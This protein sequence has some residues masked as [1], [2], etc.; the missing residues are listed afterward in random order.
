MIHFPWAKYPSKGD[1]PVRN[2]PMTATINAW[3]KK[4]RPRKL[5]KKLGKVQVTTAPFMK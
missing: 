5:I 3:I 4:I 1:I 2:N